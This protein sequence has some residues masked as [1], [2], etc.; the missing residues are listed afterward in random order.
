MTVPLTLREIAI[1]AAQDASAARTAIARGVLADVLQP[2]DVAGLDVVDDTVE[3]VVFGDTDGTRLSVRGDAVA[4]V[5]G[6]TGGA[7]TNL[8]AVGSLVELG[9]MLGAG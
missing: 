9:A 6:E 4:L 3:V 8:G 1:Q 7:W 5:D 2:A